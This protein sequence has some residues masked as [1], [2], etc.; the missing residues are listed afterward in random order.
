MWVK[1]YW[2]V[3]FATYSK[4]I[5]DFAVTLDFDLRQY[6]FPASSIYFFFKE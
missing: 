3:E 6:Y 2:S 5:S 1:K 4:A